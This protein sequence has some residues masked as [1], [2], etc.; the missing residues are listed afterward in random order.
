MPQGSPRSLLHRLGN[1][2][3]FILD[4]RLKMLSMLGTGYFLNIAKINFQQEKPICPNRQNS[5]PQITKQK[6][7][8][9]ISCHTVI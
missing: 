4:P 8:K 2:S 7:K 5:F 3:V 6:K 1:Q 9:K